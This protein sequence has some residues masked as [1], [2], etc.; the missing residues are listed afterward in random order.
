[1]K[2]LFTLAMT[3]TMTAAAAAANFQTDSFTTNEG[4]AITITAIKHSSL[5]IQYDG[6]EIQV[7]PVGKG[8]AP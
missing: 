6:L 4:K 7:D 2:T 5:R 3:T 8:V 1:M